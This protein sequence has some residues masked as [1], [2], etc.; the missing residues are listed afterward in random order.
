VSGA[1]QLAAY[2]DWFAL[3]EE[4]RKGRQG[5]IALATPLVPAVVWLILI[6]GAVVV[7][8]TVGFFADSREAALPQAAMI[9][10]VAI[11]VISALILVR[12]LDNPYEEKSGSIRPAAMER[13]L[14]QMQREAGPRGLA[15]CV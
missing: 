4:R 8:A 9:A 13:T 11:I 2:E 7:I 14:E 15:P 12:F 6:I 5:R 3:N 1:K 10:V